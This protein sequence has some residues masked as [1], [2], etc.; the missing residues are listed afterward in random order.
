MRS[1]TFETLTHGLALGLLAVVFGPRAA[2]EEASMQVYECR[3]G[4]TVTYSG[5]P[6]GAQEQTMDLQ[7]ERPSAAAAQAATQTAIRQGEK[8]WN[9]AQAVVLD[10]QILSTAQQA[11]DL[12]TQRDARVAALRNELNRGTEN[13]NPDAW[14]AGL[15]QQIASTVQNYNNQILALRQQLDQLKSQRAAL[16]PAPAP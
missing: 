14:Q 7:Y 10:N 9:Q 6:C 5:A 8:A 16:G 2:A 4:D 15:R 3:Q 11:S 13:P 1:M 12:E